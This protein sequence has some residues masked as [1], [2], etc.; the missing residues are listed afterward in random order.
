[1]A[2]L[3]LSCANILTNVFS[4]FIGKRTSFDLDVRSGMVVLIQD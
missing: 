3:C 4:W 2:P 1:M